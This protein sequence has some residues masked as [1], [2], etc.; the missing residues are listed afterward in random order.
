MRF[1]YKPANK[2]WQTVIA[3]SRQRAKNLPVGFGAAGRP[4]AVFGTQGV[5]L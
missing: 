5:S 2:A 4:S 1:T 3:E